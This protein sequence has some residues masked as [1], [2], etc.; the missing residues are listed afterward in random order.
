M[1]DTT[2]DFNC[3]KGWWVGKRELGDHLFIMGWSH[4]N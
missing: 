3:L 4:E 2:T 1:E